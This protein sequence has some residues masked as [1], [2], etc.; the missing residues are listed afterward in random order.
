[1]T[2]SISLFV[3]F[4]SNYPHN[5]VAKV[6]G[7]TSIGNHLQSKFNQ[8]YERSGSRGVMTDFYTMLDGGNREIL[9]NWIEANYKG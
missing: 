3:N 7:D 1:M 4:S 9:C 5:F 2:K 6:W 8:A